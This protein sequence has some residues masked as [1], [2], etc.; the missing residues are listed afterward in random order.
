[1][2]NL[3][4]AKGLALVLACALLAMLAAGAAA[5]DGRWDYIVDVDASGNICYTFGEVI[6][7]LPADWADNYYMEVGDDYVAFYQ[8]ASYILSQY[9]YGYPGGWLFSVGY[10][11]TTDYR[12][13]PSYDELGPGAEGYYFLA[14]PTDYQAYIED[15][16]V[17]RQYDQMWK[18]VDFVARNSYSFIFHTDP[19]AEPQEE[20]AKAGGKVGG[21]S[22]AVSAV[23][24]E[25]EGSIAFTEASAGF[26][27]TW[28]PFQD[29]FK[30]YLPSEWVYYVLNDQETAKG[31]LYHA[32]ND[33]RDSV[34]GNVRM[35]VVVC[36]SEAGQLRTLGDLE[37]K[38]ESK[39]TGV[40]KIGINGIPCVTYESVD[41]DHRGIAFFHPGNSNY[42]FTIGV[43]PYGANDQTVS[44]V[45]SAILCSVSPYAG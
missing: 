15:D 11:E 12:D 3:R 17:R 30:I 28:V 34:V 9:T 22:G 26:R 20:E 32:G 7:T 29:G 8:T 44:N 33:G 13:Q 21:V 1:M 25:L 4:G 19:V 45:G 23:N 38:L 31:V 24:D 35:D 10:S 40:S 2:R 42:I 5:E 36:Y 39:Y 43:S 27:G 14:Y 37:A 6:V 16:S 41:G 18:G